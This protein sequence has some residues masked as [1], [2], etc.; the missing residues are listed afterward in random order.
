V[1][2][3]HH[4]S[5]IGFIAW[6]TYDGAGN[7]KWYFASSCRFNGNACTGTL[8]ETNG[9]PFGSPFSAN[10]VVVRTVGNMTINFSG[11]GNAVMSYTV[12]G[13]AAS[14]AIT[15]LAF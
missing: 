7:P 6:Y 5:G 10:A 2:I 15:K 14:K 11:A 3:T 1:S 8:Y 12:N 9:P 13:V 4:A